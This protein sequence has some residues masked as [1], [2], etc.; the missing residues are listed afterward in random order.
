M[1]GKMPE[2]FR[3]VPQRTKPGERAPRGP[4]PRETPAAETALHCPTEGRPLTADPVS[5]P[6]SHAWPH[7]PRADETLQPHLE[8]EE[9]GFP[10]PPSSADGPQAIV[11][12]YLCSTLGQNDEIKSRSEQKQGRNEDN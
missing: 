10:G 4:L 9:H 6:S 12:R 11:R 8:A 5:H 2:T 7:Q 3:A 1:M